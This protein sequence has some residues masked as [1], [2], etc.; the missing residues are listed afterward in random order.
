[1]TCFSAGRIL[2]NETTK[3]YYVESNKKNYENHENYTNCFN[4]VYSANR[5]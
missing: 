4:L 1:M 5:I 3:S 2:V